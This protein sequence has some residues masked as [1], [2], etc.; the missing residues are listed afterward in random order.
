V[1]TSVPPAIYTIPPS[2]PI[3]NCRYVYVYDSTPEVVYCGYLPGY[4]GCY[5]YGPTIVYGTGY[6]YPAWFGV[7]Y[8][9]R[10]WTWGV[11]AYFDFWSGTWGFGLGYAWGPVW[12]VR[13][14]HRHGWWGPGGYRDWRSLHARDVR[15]DRVN[16]YNHVENINRNVNVTN[17]GRR[18]NAR[19]TARGERNDVFAGRDGGVYRRTPE[20]WEQRGERGWTRLGAAP[21]ERRAVQPHEPA[22]ARPAPAAGAYGRP[23][24]RGLETEHLGRERGAS[25]AFDLGT[26]GGSRRG[27]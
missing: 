4:T 3:Y 15:T 22:G 9:A 24:E 27:R 19:V 16:I 10:P 23:S 26:R 6:G 5:V 8:I 13:D 21:E 17:V 12:F 25:R 1:C 18:P 7:E 14:H 2:C 11:G 20:G